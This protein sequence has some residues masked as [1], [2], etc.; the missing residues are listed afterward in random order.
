MPK[1]NQLVHRSELRPLPMRVTQV[2]FE[3]LQRL[4]KVD[5]LA[6]Q[7]H[8]RRSI[9]DY[10]ERKE[11]RYPVLRDMPPVKIDADSAPGDDMAD[12]LHESEN[13]PAPAL[14]VTGQLPQAAPRTRPRVRTR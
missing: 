2:Q 5:G 14:D 3:R 6:I 1:T 8:V 7:E 13:V 9:D 11:A 12:A 10:L 4:R